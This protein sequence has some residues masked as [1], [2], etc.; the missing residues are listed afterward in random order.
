MNIQRCEPL[1]ARRTFELRPYIHFGAGGGVFL[2]ILILLIFIINPLIAVLIA[3]GTGYAVY[4]YLESR[5]LVVACSHCRKD[6]NTNTPW[7]CGFQ[8]CQNLN[9]DEFPFVRE[10]ETCHYIPKAYQCHHCGKTISL[11]TDPQQLHAAR[12]LENLELPVKI[13]VIDPTKDKVLQQ[14]VEIGDL[15]HE[16][17]VE[18]LR[19]KIAIEKN[20][21][22][23]TSVAKTPDEILEDEIVEGIKHDDTLHDIERRL[24]DKEDAKFPAG[25]PE[26]ERAYARI[27]AQILK[28]LQ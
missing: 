18:T 3:G 1:K 10:C 25:S 27:D 20:K 23:T 7:Q 9:V 6:I 4:Y 12:R 17:G 26:R 13:V 22:V 11:T 24:K 2:I 16:L 8:G 21:P 14:K 19:K 15:E 28:H 5:L